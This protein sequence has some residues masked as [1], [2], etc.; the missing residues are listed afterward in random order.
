MLPD[1]LP[2]LRAS[3]VTL[4]AFEQRDAPLIQS[5]ASD[6]LIPLITTVPTSGTRTDALAFIERQHDRL[7]SGA[8]Y[9]FAIADASTG[10]AVGQ[11][12]LWLRAIDDGRASVGYWV[13]ARHRGRGY[14]KTALRTLTT[15]ALSCDEVDRLELYVE[16][17]NEGSWRTAEQCGFVREGLLRSWQAVGGLRRDMFMYSLV[18][19][20]LGLHD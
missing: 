4:R 8:G 18:A 2:A 17:W 3:T 11:I 5:V 14:A 1:V 15:W 13:A 9:S 7:T 10:E 6:D 20:D 12:G 16:P 19:Q